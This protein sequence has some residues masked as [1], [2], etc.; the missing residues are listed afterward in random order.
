MYAPS[1]LILPADARPRLRPVRA[2]RSSHHLSSADTGLI[3]RTEML[4]RGETDAS[5]RVAVRDGTLRR[6]AQG[7]YALDDAQPGTIAPLRHG[8]RLTCISV[9][10]MHGLW[11]PHGD[12][13]ARPGQSIS[14]LHV[15]RYQ[16]TR[17]TPPRMAGHPTPHRGWPEQD[18]VA[19]LPLALEHAMRCQDGE[20]AAILLES[21]MAQ[22]L[23]DPV[24]VTALLT[25][26]PATVRSRI[27]RLST[28]SDSGSETRVVRWLRRRGFTVEQQVYLED[29]GYLDAYVGGIFLEID[30]RGPHT[31]QEVFE[32]DRA[33]DLTATSLGLQVLRISYQQV[34]L[35][36]ARTQRKILAAIRQVGPFGRAKVRALAGRRSAA[37]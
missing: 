32:A 29:V 35:D 12:S 16:D 33:R 8:H 26:A 15:Y 5:I 14:R 25:A 3:S 22:G 19:S 30:G 1:T 4:A 31:A 17:D 7:W 2:P 10:P 28:A 6:V 11:T 23:L 21:A 13:S 20:T 24:E 9:T 37:A 27:G 18:P 34:W 36:W